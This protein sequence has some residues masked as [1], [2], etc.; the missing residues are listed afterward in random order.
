MLT[1]QQRRQYARLRRLRWDATYALERARN[2]SGPTLYTSTRIWQKPLTGATNPDGMKWIE[3]PETAF[4]LVKTCDTGWYLDREFMDETVHGVVYQLP[5][6]RFIA[7][8]ADP[9][10]DG[11][12]CLD[13]TTIHDN[14]SDAER[15]AD[16]H[17]RIMAEHESEYQEAWRAGSRARM[18]RADATAAARQ[19]KE[20]AR[21]VCELFAVRHK[22]PGRGAMRS[23]I[24]AARQSRARF[25]RAREESHNVEIATWSDAFMEGY[26][27]C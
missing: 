25:E 15:M 2:Y 7:G 27:S 11:P 6:G 16:E 26:A 3:D 9:H 12:A 21:A 13:V 5:H 19:W 23:L 8:Y 22:V 4:R 20:D 18:I 10:N 17:A 14:E 1:E 24:R